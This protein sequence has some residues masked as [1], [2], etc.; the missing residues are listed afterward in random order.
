MLTLRTIIC[1]LLLTL[2]SVIL[3]VPAPYR[4]GIVLFEDPSGSEVQVDSSNSLGKDGNSEDDKETGGNLSLVNGPGRVRK[5][6]PD[7]YPS[8]EH[9]GRKRQVTKTLVVVIMT[10]VNEGDVIVSTPCTTTTAEVAPVPVEITTSTP[11]DE[12]STPVAPVVE[13]PTQSGPPCETTEILVP[14]EEPPSTTS[15]QGPITVT[16]IVLPV[17][18]T[19]TTT[20]PT[21]T[22]A[23]VEETTTPCEIVPTIVPVNPTDSKPDYTITSTDNPIAIIE[24]TIVTESPTSNFSNISTSTIETVSS[25]TT[26]TIPTTITTSTKTINP[27]EIPTFSF[28]LLPQEPV[29][30][31]DGTYANRPTSTTCPTTTTSTTPTTTTVT[32][33][34]TTTTPPTTTTTTTTTT[35]TTTTT[36]SPTAIIITIPN[37]VTAAPYPTVVV[38]SKVLDNGEL[39][40]DMFGDFLMT[41]LAESTQTQVP[42]NCAGCGEQIS[43]PF[44]GGGESLWVRGPLMVSVFVVVVGVVGWWV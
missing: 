6:S 19:P 24:T 16:M 14:V 34:T 33:S 26:T 44:E 11:C 18:D 39:D 17:P 21:T 9:E 3:A 22:E 43:A 15:T 35:A 29:T 42:G 2:T 40:L 5:K 20:S 30:T 31:R 1:F 38:P 7:T 12:I 36:T 4:D 28:I 41:E 23:P 37:E 32:T 10:T 27:G 25:T 13:E 8:K